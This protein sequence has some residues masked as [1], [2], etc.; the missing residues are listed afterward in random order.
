MQNKEYRRT[1]RP[2]F[3]LYSHFMAMFRRTLRG[4]FSIY[5]FLVFLALLLVVF[6]F[7]VLASLFGK[8]KG[9]NMIYDICEVWA[10][11]GMAFW[12][13]RHRN[14]YEAPHHPGHPLVFVFNHNSYMDI[15]VIM[16]TFRRQHY[17][18][19]GKAEMGRIP[20]FGFIY[21]NAVVMVNR[22]N[23]AARAKSVSRLMATLRKN[24]SIVIAPEG[25]FNTTGEPLKEFY[26]GAFRIAIETGTPVKPVL[27]LDAA[28]RLHHS[29]IFSLS[30]GRSRSVFLEE[31][32]VDG[33]T[34]N[35]VPLL[36]EKVYR[37]MEEGLIRYNVSWLDGRK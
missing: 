5:G 18:V 28:D 20:V 31:I 9:G 19:L 4:L 25:T 24:I 12:G 13:I 37:I 16:K 21:R 2:L 36:K 34:M 26:D 3:H 22:N 35:D 7:V 32:P 33:L 11:I 14:I 23:A 17:R 27:F 1:G 8:V 10:D 29:S 15:P 30:P 6:P